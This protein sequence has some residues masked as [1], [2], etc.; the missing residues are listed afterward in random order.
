M[1]YGQKLSYHLLPFS[2]ANSEREDIFT[3]KGRGEDISTRKGR[4]GSP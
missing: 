4:N 2:F 1:E 3:R